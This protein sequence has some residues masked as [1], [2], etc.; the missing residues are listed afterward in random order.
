MHE[1]KLFRA[2]WIFSVMFLLAS[3]G[4]LYVVRMSEWW[5]LPILIVL[6]LPV[7]FLL[8]LEAASKLNG[9]K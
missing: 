9:G 2:M 3:Q 4:L 7:A 1:W 5:V 8:T 6:S